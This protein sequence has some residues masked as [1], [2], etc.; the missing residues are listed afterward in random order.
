MLIPTAI[1][2]V[3]SGGGVTNIVYETRSSNTILG[4][5][6]KGKAIEFT[7]SFTQTF[8]AAA[9]L[10]SGW[11]CILRA[12]SDANLVVVTLDANS[13]ELID[14]IIT[15]RLC[16]GTTILVTC[17]GSAFTTLTLQGCMGPRD[18]QTMQAWYDFSDTSTIT[19]A[20]GGAVSQVTDKSGKG[21]T[22][23]EATNRPTTGTRTLN[24]LNVLDFDGTND[25]LRRTATLLMEVAASYIVVEPDSV[26]GTQVL[27]KSQA[28]TMSIFLS[29][30]TVTG[31]YHDDAA[32]STVAS[33]A[34]IGVAALYAVRSIMWSYYTRANGT[35][36]AIGTGG[37]VPVGATE[38]NISSNTGGGSLPF[39][40]KIAEILLLSGVDEEEDLAIRNYL[41]NKWAVTA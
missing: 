39:N 8:T 24:G 17:D 22:I 30:T 20:G 25:Q 27:F 6:D 1:Q 37:N 7:A 29:G 10:G 40:G 36:G 35:N 12:K 9:T 23:S 38:L 31:N 21:H 28:N 13:G 3:Q 14:G 15:Q 16:A 5:A 33:G 19:D 32:S 41:A 11:W 2:Q 18:L 34:A 26:T 4:T